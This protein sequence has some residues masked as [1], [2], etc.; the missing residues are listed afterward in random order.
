MNGGDAGEA[1]SSETAAPDMVMQL[2]ATLIQGSL[3]R[4]L[5]SLVVLPPSPPS[6]HRALKGATTIECSREW[7]GMWCEWPV[8]ARAQEDK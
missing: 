4:K 7:P 5:N 6:P 2:E 1:E 8:R 3:L